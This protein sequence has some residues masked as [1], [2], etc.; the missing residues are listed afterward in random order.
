MS[1]V[2]VLAVGPD[3]P[4]AS[5]AADSGKTGERPVHTLYRQPGGYLGEVHGK[6]M[7]VL[8]GKPRKAGRRDK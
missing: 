7:S 5:W 6:W 4:D 8:I 1:R 3:S 2:L